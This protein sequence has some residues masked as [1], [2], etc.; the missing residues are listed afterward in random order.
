[1]SDTL[2]IPE[3]QDQHRLCGW[4]RKHRNEIVI[5]SCVTAAAVICGVLLYKNR[6]VIIDELKPI[7]SMFERHA[8]IS[9]KTNV[10]MRFEAPNVILTTYTASADVPAVLKGCEPFNVREHLRNLSESRTHSVEKY[11]HALQI[12][13]RLNDHQTLVESYTKSRAE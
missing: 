12:G 3:R 9:A 6:S 4:V 5:G 2:S 11:N 8:A 7:R 1:M 13:I 10:Q